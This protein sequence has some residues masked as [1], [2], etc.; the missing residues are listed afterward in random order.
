[1]IVHPI[2]AWSAAFFFTQIVEMPIYVNALARREGE[3]HT[4]GGTARRV[5]VAFGA[6]AITH[7]FVWFLFP[8]LVESY[9][10]MVILAEAFAIGA[11]AL[12][13]HLFRVRWALAWALGANLTSV[14]LGFTSRALFGVP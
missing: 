4:R 7:P 9:W 12:Y 8:E 5:L 10:T 1:M 11:E 2:A 6:S 14:T 3:P 13:L